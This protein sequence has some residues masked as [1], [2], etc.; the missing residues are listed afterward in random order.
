MK[1]IDFRFT[2]GHFPFGKY[3]LSNPFLF[4]LVHHSMEHEG[5]K[6]DFY[7]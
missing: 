2:V 1:Y 4:S 5:R 7:F 3:Y 6:I